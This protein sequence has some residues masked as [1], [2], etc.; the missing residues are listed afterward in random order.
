ME[1]EE[2][3]K[4]I[5]HDGLWIPEQMDNPSESMKPSDVTRDSYINHL[6]NFMSDFI[7]KTRIE[8]YALRPASHAVIREESE[9]IE[10]VVE[11]LYQEHP[12][13]YMMLGEHITDLWRYRD[14]RVAG[15]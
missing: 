3:R 14:P 5:E 9:P 6:D 10:K 1:P 8:F 12:E 13:E 15:K 2:E 7:H 4:F 11:R